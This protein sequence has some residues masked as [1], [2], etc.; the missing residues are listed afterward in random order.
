MNKREVLGELGHLAVIL[1]GALV[2]WFMQH[3]IEAYFMLGI[4]TLIVWVVSAPKLF[5][6]NPIGTL[7]VPLMW[8]G[9]LIL[10]YVWLAKGMPGRDE[11]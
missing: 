2:L 9:M 11:L 7:F 8:P 10:W 4:I 3:H 1:F 5:K 6:G